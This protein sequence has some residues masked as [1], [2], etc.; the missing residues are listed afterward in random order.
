MRAAIQRLIKANKKRMSDI[1][2][3]GELITA[4]ESGVTSEIKYQNMMLQAILNTEGLG[5]TP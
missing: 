2:K 5:D 4:H 1:R 3:S